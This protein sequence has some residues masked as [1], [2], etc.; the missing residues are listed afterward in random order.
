MVL[1]KKYQKPLGTYFDYKC[2]TRIDTNKEFQKMK[3]QGHMC[4][5]E[6]LMGCQSWQKLPKSNQ[7]LAKMGLLKNIK[8][9]CGQTAL[10]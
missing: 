3:F 2:S 4:Y 1:L 5:H 7:N 6:C 9:S 8:K 10:T